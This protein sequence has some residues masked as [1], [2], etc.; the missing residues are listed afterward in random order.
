MMGQCGRWTHFQRQQGQTRDKQVL[1]EYSL[2]AGQLQINEVIKL[3]ILEAQSELDPWVMTAQLMAWNLIAA[4]V[5]WSRKDIGIKEVP[6]KV[7]PE[8]AGNVGAILG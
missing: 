6:D 5:T 8:P 4:N 7:C 2:T 1:V 3:K